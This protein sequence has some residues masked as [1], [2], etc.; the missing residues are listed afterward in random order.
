[1]KLRI[2]LVAAVLMTAFLLPA[3]GQGDALPVAANLSA[4]C[5]NATT[6]CDA[7]ANSQLSVP[8]SSFA[9]AAVSVSGTYTGVTLNFD[10]STD[11]AVTWTPVTCT[12]VDTPIV[13]AGEVLGTNDSKTW[14]CP[15]FG[16]SNFRVRDNAIST[17]KNYVIVTLVRM[18]TNLAPSN[19]CSAL[20][21]GIIPVPI[22]QTASTKIISQAAGKKNIICGG[23]I[24]TA[25][26]EIVNIVEGTGS[27]CGTGTAAIAGSTTAAN[28]MSFAA[29]GGL[30]IVSFIPGIGTN[31]DTCLTQS[32]SNRVAGVLVVVQVPV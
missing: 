11:G 9:M 28:G 31:V 14:V 29:N 13:E 16:S 30:S 25:A 15:I 3:F 24:F 21:S 10:R 8:S 18:P 7:T 19:P 1:M 32:G 23:F 22:S 26:A 4:A 5:T 27:T 12:R 20:T 6:T 2:S 17:G